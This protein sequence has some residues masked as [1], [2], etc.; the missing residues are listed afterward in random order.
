MANKMIARTILFS[1]A[2]VNVEAL[3]VPPISKYKIRYKI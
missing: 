3:T 1:Y 2:R